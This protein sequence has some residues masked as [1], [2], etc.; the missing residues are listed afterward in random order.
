MDKPRCYVENRLDMTDLI[1]WQSSKNTVAEVDSY[2][3]EGVDKSRCN[4]DGQ[5][6]SNKSNATKLVETRAHQ[7]V[8]MVCH[9]QAFVKVHPEIANR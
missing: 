2:N 3:D 8:N 6:A 7:S 1:P 4:H 5:R 9:G